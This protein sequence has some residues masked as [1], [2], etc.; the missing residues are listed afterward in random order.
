MLSP[1]LSPPPAPTTLPEKADFQNDDDVDDN[2]DDDDDDD[3]DDHGDA[4]TGYA[5]LDSPLARHRSPEC[6]VYAL[7][8]PFT[9]EASR[10]TGKRSWQGYWVSRWALFALFCSWVP[11]KTTQHKGSP[12]YC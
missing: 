11:D 7:K 4:F 3:D 8:R 5:C 12:F 2:D 1:A 10:S 6:R 9:A